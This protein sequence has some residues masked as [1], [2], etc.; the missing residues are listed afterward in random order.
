MLLRMSNVIS[1]RNSP[2]SLGQTAPETS[3]HTAHETAASW[4]SRPIQLI[5]VC[6][7]ILLFIVIAITAGLL[8]NLRDRDLAEKARAL[9]S[10]TLVLAEQ[11]DRSFQ[12]I[13]LVQTA[14]IERMRT[15]GVASAED[16]ERQMSDYD[17]YERLKDTIKGLPYINA[18]V[19]TDAEG[20]LINFSRSWPIP[21]VKIPGQDPSRVFKSDP[22]LIS[23]V[24]KPL[25]SPVTGNWV[26]SIARKLTGPNGEFLGVIQ[27][28]MELRY[29]EQTFQVISSGPNSSI[30][31]FQRNG[32]MLARYPHQETAIGQFFPQSRFLKILAIS[33]H[34]TTPAS[35]RD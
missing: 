22:Q 1:Q 34:G 16:F 13:E 27:G 35:W 17:T 5:I 8:S 26:V 23:F 3:A 32:L 9:E 10:L 14:V 11:I 4:R 20:K 6:G 15:Y 12:S 21:S 25:R 7:I 18:I 24:G 31:L 29:F 28:A 19:L 2:D 33:D 30:A